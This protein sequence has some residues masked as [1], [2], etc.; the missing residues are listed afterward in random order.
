[1]AF[2]IERKFLV[3]ELPPEIDRYPHSEIMQG[4]LMITDN[5]I[6]VRVRK[7][8]GHCTH[9]V[10][11]GSGL[12]RKEAEKEITEAEFFEHWPETKGKRVLKVRYDIDYE[13]FLIELDIYS[14]DLQGLV[15]AEVEFDSEEESSHFVPPKWFGEEITLDERYKN[16]NLAL[17]GK[18]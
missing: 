4:Y 15:V 18:P 5:D 16:K 14:G 11:S 7:R 13:E 6:E 1:M 3:N 12:V 2:E 8:G 10:K 17:H 9:T